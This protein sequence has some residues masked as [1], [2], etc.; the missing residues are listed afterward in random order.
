MNIY[1]QSYYREILQMR[2]DQILRIKDS[3][4]LQ[5]ISRLLMLEK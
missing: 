3:I 5:A 2:T 1:F 4:N